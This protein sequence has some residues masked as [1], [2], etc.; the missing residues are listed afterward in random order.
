MARESSIWNRKRR[1]LLKPG[2]GRENF[3]LGKGYFLSKVSFRVRAATYG[4]SYGL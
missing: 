4:Q 2:K 1:V 3:S